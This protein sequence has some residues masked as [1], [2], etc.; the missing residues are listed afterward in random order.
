ME[1]RMS[2]VIRGAI[3]VVVLCLCGCASSAPGPDPVAGLRDELNS[4]RAQ[5]AQVSARAG[6]LEQRVRALEHSNLELQREVRRLQ[7][8]QLT[9]LPPPP[10]LTPTN[11]APHL[12]PLDT[13]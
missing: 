12:T 6:A 4:A 9:P 13:P 1:S 2:S 11:R 10:P 3:L 5:L 7:A 8:P